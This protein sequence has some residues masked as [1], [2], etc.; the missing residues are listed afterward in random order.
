[1]P[2]LLLLLAFLLTCCASA[3][4]PGADGSEPVDVDLNIYLGFKS[5]ALYDGTPQEQLLTSLRVYVFFKNGYL[6][7]TDYVYNASG[8]TGN[9]EIRQMTVYSG[10]KTFCIIG[11]EPSGLTSS[12]Q[13]I[14]NLWDLQAL[15]VSDIFNLP[16][17]LLPF[18]ATKQE[19]ITPGHTAPIQIGLQRAVAKAEMKIIK[20][21]SNTDVVKLVGTQIVNTPNRSRLMDGVAPGASSVSLVN[22]PA[23]SF[24]FATVGSTASDTLQM[25]PLYLF[26]HLTGTGDA[27]ANNATLL[28]VELEINGAQQIFTIPL[29]VEGPAGQKLNDVIRNYIY[30]MRLTVFPRSIRI[31]YT[32]RPW[33]DEA[34]WNKEAGRDDSNMEFTT[35]DDEPAYPHN[36]PQP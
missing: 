3:D 22:L 20:D 17:A 34:P 21:D 5:A 12:L 2:L 28:K 30:R 11:N 36:L 13:N 15:M 10:D 14:K 4:T 23:E 8:L 24:A 35:W 31:D 18:T 19:T 7:N 27:V 25:A 16:G 32:I 26:E 6:D 9:P 29:R 33:D 1:M